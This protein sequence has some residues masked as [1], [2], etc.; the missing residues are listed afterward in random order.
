MQKQIIIKLFI[1][2]I[3]FTSDLFA[4]N[5]QKC[6]W[7][8]KKA[9]PCLTISKTSNTSA[10]S[11]Q[12][13]NK[14]VISKQDIINSGDDSPRALLLIYPVVVDSNST[15]PLI[16]ISVSFPMTRNKG[17]T[18]YTIPTKHYEDIDGDTEE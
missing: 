10:Y 7:N 9:I 15:D 6:K 8:S 16:G 2:L 14:I 17:H 11:T 4:K 5:L 18:M 13:V 1:F 12:G 3:F